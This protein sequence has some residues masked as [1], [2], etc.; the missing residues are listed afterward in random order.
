MFRT[1]P[2]VDLVILPDVRNSPEVIDMRVIPID[3][4][5]MIAVCYTSYPILTSFKIIRVI[6][7]T[8]PY[9]YFL[10]RLHELHQSPVDLIDVFVSEI[11]RPV[12]SQ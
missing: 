9:T 8:R 11:S 12:V 3:P 5:R 2:V 6:V 1:K 7:F 10:I 4:Y